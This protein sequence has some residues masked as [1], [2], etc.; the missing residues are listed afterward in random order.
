MLEGFDEAFAS[1]AFA[2]R[3]IDRRREG[4]FEASREWLGVGGCRLA[5][6]VAAA[7]TLS[8]LVCGHRQ[9]H[10]FNLVLRVA[11]MLTLV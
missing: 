8:V 9:K 2:D 1:Y 5:E 7:E 6:Q 11:R 4:V 10:L 3:D